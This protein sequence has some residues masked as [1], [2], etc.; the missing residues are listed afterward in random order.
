MAKAATLRAR[1]GKALESPDMPGTQ[2][3]AGSW[4]QDFGPSCLPQHFPPVSFA[5]IHSNDGGHK[6]SYTELQMPV[7][8][9][10]V[11]RLLTCHTCKNW[12][13]RWE[14]LDALHYLFRFIQKSSKRS[15]GGLPSP[16]DT[17]TA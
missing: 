6:D 11:G 2:P 16:P 8:G 7:L 13:I 17:G 14:A 1:A 15:C 4:L 3:W 9:K 5:Q 12:Q 10:L